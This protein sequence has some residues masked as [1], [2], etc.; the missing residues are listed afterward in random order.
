MS[1]TQ[2]E[3]P[4]SS[5]KTTLIVSKQRN[6]YLYALF[7]VNY[8]IKTPTNSHTYILGHP[9]YQIPN[10]REFSESQHEISY[11]S[12]K[13]TLIVSKQRKLYLYA[14]FIVNYPIKTP[15]NSH[16]YILG[17]PQYQIP[18][19]REFSKSQLEYPPL[20]LVL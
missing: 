6:L 2:H 5:L 15:A 8:P 4:Y 19:Y 3:I 1:H 20:S 10:Y 18:N 12:L 9:Q 11:N 13:T 14:L 16:T 7:I 17:H